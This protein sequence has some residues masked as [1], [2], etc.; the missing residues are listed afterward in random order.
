MDLGISD[1][2]RPLLEEVKNFIDQE[3]MPLE[4]ENS[5]T[6]IKIHI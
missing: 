2:V 5:K 3:I 1:N 6:K 4:G